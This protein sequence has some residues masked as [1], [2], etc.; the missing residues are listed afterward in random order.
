MTIDFEFNFVSFEWRFANFVL[1]DYIPCLQT[2]V[3]SP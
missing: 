3:Y 2:A 1:A